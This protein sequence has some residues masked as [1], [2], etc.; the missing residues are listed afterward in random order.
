LPV[1]VGA[2][3]AVVVAIAVASIVLATFAAWIQ[4]DLE[5]V[6][7]YS[8]V[9]DAGVIM[10]AFA[11]L[12]PA[13]WTPGRTW[14]LAFVVTRSAFAAWA[15]VVRDSFWTGRLP[16]LRGWAIRSPI[17]GVGLVIIIVASIG[18]PGF[19]A[20]Q[21][22]SE[23]VDLALDGPLQ[24][25]VLVATFAPILYYVR[26]LAI[27]SRRLDITSAPAVDWRPHWTAMD[28]TD[29]RGS[30]TRLL[31]ANRTI[32]ATALSVV[33]ALVALLTSIGAFGGP[34]AAAGLPPALAIPGEST[35]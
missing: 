3:R 35:P 5:H 20:F 28:L 21:A 12:D 33:L 31:T 23:L 25:L 22:R 27:G 1:D 30:A 10:L 17:L 19:A 15:A 29:I 6:V 2:E 16:D 18:L 4:D 13:A 7:G 8:I 9:G 24:A 11:A 14:I 32:G 26:L 34:Q